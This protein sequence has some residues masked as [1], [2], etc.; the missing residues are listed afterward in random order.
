MYE[1]RFPALGKSI[2]KLDNFCSIIFSVGMLFVLLFLFSATIVGT[3]GAIAWVLARILSHGRYTQVYFFALMALFV[4]VP[5]SAS[6]ADRRFGKRLVPGSRGY[7]TVHT[8]LRLSIALNLVQFA[9]PVMWTLMSNVGRK[10]A[11]GVLYAG[12]MGI[13]LISAADLLLRRGA[14]GINNYDFYGPS[15][16]HSVSNA[17]YENQRT[18]SA[19][20]RAPMIQSDIIRDP[21]VRL[22]IPYSPPR[23]NVGLARACPGLKPLQSEGVQFGADNFV[24][25]SLSIPALQCMAKVHAVKLDSA[26]VSLDFAFYEHPGTGLRGVIGYIPIASL[27]AGRHVITVMPVPPPNPPTD[28]AALANAPWKQPYVIPFWK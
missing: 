12:L 1:E 24:P 21:Y 5:V 16:A 3:A 27:A 14:L 18:S 22:F 20:P 13:I 26:P 25:D 8:L 7:R 28:S 23:H 11:V 2:A 6:L 10:K 17:F 9:G 4:A 15:N 19:S